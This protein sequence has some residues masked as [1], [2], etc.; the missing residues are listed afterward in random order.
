MWEMDFETL[1]LVLKPHSL[2]LNSAWCSFVM[3]LFISGPS[4]PTKSHFPHLTR[5][6]MVARGLFTGVCFL[7]PFFGPGLSSGSGFNC[8]FIGATLPPSF[9]NIKASKSIF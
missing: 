6:L 9:F 8:T 7:C 2:H 1:Y 4:L 3:C 5:G